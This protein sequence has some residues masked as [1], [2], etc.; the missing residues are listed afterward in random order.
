MTKNIDERPDNVGSAVPRFQFK[1]DRE[2]N[3]KNG[4]RLP[5]PLGRPVGMR[6]AD[7]IR[8]ASGLPPRFV[9]KD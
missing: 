7:R 2:L 8:R 4:P 5:N 6:G 1:A 9:G 3:Q